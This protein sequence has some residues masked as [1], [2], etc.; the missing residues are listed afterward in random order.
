M[1]IHG[2]GVFFYPRWDETQSKQPP[3]GDCRRK[4]LYKAHTPSPLLDH[5]AQSVLYD[6]TL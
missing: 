5:V 2:G 6:I 1:F 4:I 3:G